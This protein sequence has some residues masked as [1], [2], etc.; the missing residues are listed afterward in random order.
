LYDFGKAG[1]LSAVSS[2]VEEL[3]GKKPISFS[4]FTKDY[5]QAFEDQVAD[6]S[7]GPSITLL[8]YLLHSNLLSKP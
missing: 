7:L 2:A 5:A 8:F 6:T 4:Q 3:T 1:N